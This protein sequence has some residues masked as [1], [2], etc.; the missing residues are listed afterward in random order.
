MLIWVLL[1]CLFLEQFLSL[2]NPLI[3]TYMLLVLTNIGF[4]FSNIQVAVLVLVS[5][6]SEGT[7]FSE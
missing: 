7:D 1:S 6:A 4:F 3:I 2:Y 5:S